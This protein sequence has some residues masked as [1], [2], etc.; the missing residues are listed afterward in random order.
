MVLALLFL[1]TVLLIF[2]T[3]AW[4]SV[5]LNVKIKFFEMNVSSN[6]GLFISLDGIDFSDSVEITSKSIIDNLKTRYPTNTNQWA[7]KGLWPISTI[8]I[9]HPNQDK[10]EIYEGTLVKA[11]DKDRK[12]Y[13]FLN[14]A[15]M[16]EDSSN[17]YKSYLAFDIFLKNVSGS[18]KSDNLYIDEGTY[19][20]FGDD[21]DEESR[22]EMDGIINSIRF[23]FLKI[24]STSSNDEIR[25]IQ[26]LKCNNDCAAVIYEP[27]K[28]KHSPLS[29]ERAYTDYGVTLVDGEISPTYAIIK[30][31]RRLEYANGHE[32]SGIPLDTEHFQFQETIMES[33]FIDPI[34]Q[35]PNGITK[36]RIYVW[37]EGQDIDSLE[38]NSEGAPIFLAIDLLKDLAGYMDF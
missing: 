34:F 19:I 31:G 4:F 15:H 9:K 29:I 20:D 1:T 33:Q 23:G 38:T 37:L 35:I 11:R 36:M 13:R 24:G 7:A 8:G 17:L 3:Y 27:N 25:N 26:N 18:P 16:P 32:G 6:S 28:I 30:E 21:V 10:F 2:V 22:I 5:S 12:L 14:T